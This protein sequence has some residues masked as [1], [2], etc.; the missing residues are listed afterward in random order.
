MATLHDAL[1]SSVGEYSKVTF[2]SFPAASFR[3][4]NSFLYFCSFP[5]KHSGPAQRNAGSHEW[6]GLTYFHP[7]RGRRLLLSSP[8]PPCSPVTLNLMCSGVGAKQIQ[9]QGGEERRRA[10]NREWEGFRR[11]GKKEG[12]AKMNRKLQI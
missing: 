10:S 3:M 5:L 2:D 1:Y 4:P 9:Q 11:R 8:S 7:I 12:E 6:A